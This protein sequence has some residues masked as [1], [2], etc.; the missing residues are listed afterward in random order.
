MTEDSKQNLL[1]FMMGKIDEETGDNKAYF[2]KMK[3]YQNNFKTKID[4]T[5]QNFELLGTVESQTNE[6]IV[7]W[8][9]RSDTGISDT[10]VVILDRKFNILKTIT[11]YDSGTTFSDIIDIKSDS[12]GRFFAL[13][14]AMDGSWTRLVMMNDLTDF[15]SGDYHCELRQSYQIP[16]EYLNY[17][18]QKVDKSL[19]NAYYTF[20]G[21][22]NNGNYGILTL[23]VNVGA[24]NEWKFVYRYIGA[25]CLVKDTLLVWSDNIQYTI[26]LDGQNGHYYEIYVGESDGNLFANLIDISY[27]N[28]GWLATNLGSIKSLGNQNVY[29]TFVGLSQDVTTA[30][31]RIY[32]L[33]YQ[34]NSFDLISE[35]TSYQ[36]SLPTTFFKVDKSNN[37]FLGVIKPP[38]SQEELPTSKGQIFMVTNENLINIIPTDEFDID[39]DNGIGTISGFIISQSFELNT[40]TLQLNDYCIYT[41][42]QMLAGGYNGKPYIDRNSLN[43]TAATV[44]SEDEP[45]L[46]RTLYNKSINANSTNSTLEIPAAYLNDIS[47][48]VKNLLSKNNN[49]IISDE[50]DY[51]KN[52][53]EN[54]YFN[55]INTIYVQN[56]NEGTSITNQQAS[57]Q[58]NA[59]INDPVNYENHKLTKFRIN[60]QD[61]TNTIAY[62]NIS[63]GNLTY[64]INFGFFVEKEAS[65][66]ELISEDEQTV[67][68]STDISNL[69]ANHVYSFSQDVTIE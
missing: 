55:F 32:K 57:N 56:R 17:I 7:G 38:I 11:N 28:T 9:H 5:I 63:K 26:Y 58:L 47:I 24:E 61:G 35:V 29:F 8:G 23:K 1:D 15:S 19:T 14:R 66:L 22:D 27:P 34:N 33:N 39:Y 52:I 2:E 20:L 54:V 67:Y 48:G 6:L 68:L 10:A 41:S 37:L 43:S 16:S 4:E 12:D 36:G 53:Y 59:D 50:K 40:L 44:Y 60:Y 21:T 69:Q 51:E 25:N 64:N 3:R 42:M 18:Y 45:V 46:T 65:T 62:F 49:V 13:E 31:V 30:Y